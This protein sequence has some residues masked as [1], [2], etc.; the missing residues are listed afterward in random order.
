MFAPQKELL[1]ELSSKLASASS[2]VKALEKALDNALKI[3]DIEKQAT[4]FREKV[5]TKMLDLRADGD[6]LEKIIAAKYWP[7]ADLR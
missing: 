2:N 4:A 5:F 7:A 6:A 3:S 1:E